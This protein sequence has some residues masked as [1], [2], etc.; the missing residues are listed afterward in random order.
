MDEIVN[1]KSEFRCKICNKDYASKS[2]LCNHIKKF[3]NNDVS[4]NIPNVS[5][6]VSKNIPNVS[7]NIIDRNTCKFCKKIY[8]SPQNRW[9]HERKCKLKDYSEKSIHETIIELKKQ[10]AF[11]LQEKGRIHH[12]TLQKINNQLTNITNNNTTNTN[13]GTINNT[14]VNFGSIDYEKI[15]TPKQICNI[16]KKNYKCIEES[17]KQV[18]FNENLP[19]YNNVFITNLRDNIGYIFNN[20]KFISVHKKVLVNDIIGYHAYEIDTSLDKYKNK[21]P[22]QT[23]EI[24]YDVIKKIND[25][26]T[27]FI[28]H[29]NNKIYNN[30]KSYK[31][32]EL[33]I[34]IYN[35]S[36]K[37]KF[38]IL[39]SN[40]LREKKLSNDTSDDESTEEI[41]I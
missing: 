33:I 31:Q 36:D 28:D 35:K 4:K 22:D 41:I 6:C 27:P 14:Y 1:N 16:L 10:V 19:E 29:E 25:D 24:V 17:I 21:L 5:I 34:I 26:N 18:H 40:E 8:S 7:N 9:K 12:K 30:Y 37:N 11:L 20:N 2:S 13:N 39:N 32:N 15:F 3:H 38:R 23:T